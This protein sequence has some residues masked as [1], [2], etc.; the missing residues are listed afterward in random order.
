MNIP[1]S[2]LE[3]FGI[4]GIPT[5]NSPRA[6][7]AHIK[8]CLSHMMNIYLVLRYD[9]QQMIDGLEQVAKTEGADWCEAYEL[10]IRGYPTGF[11]IALHFS[12]NG[13]ESVW[14][15]AFDYIPK[16]AIFTP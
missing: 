4:I 15:M 6:L 1:A 5:I 14:P 3:P 12:V 9:P 8:E 13:S 10:P 16:D 7:A 11:T 2:I